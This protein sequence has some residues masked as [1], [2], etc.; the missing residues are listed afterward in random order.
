[1][2]IPKY[3]NRISTIT[4]IALP[5][6]DMSCRRNRS[7]KIVISNQNHS[8]KIN[9]EKTSA[10]KLGNVKPPG[11]NMSVLRLHDQVPGTQPGTQPAVS[12][13]T[14][15]TPASAACKASSLVSS[16]ELR[17]TMTPAPRNPAITLSVVILRISTKRAALPDRKVL[18]VCL[19]KSSSMPQA[20]SWPPNALDEVPVPGIMKKRQ[21]NEFHGIPGTPP[22][23]IGWRSWFNFTR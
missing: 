23:V 16:N 10:R 14:A 12:T 9:I 1:M 2:N 11:N 13:D 4:Q 22:R 17:S 5:Q 7:P 20:A 18:A 6:P 3:E 8:T 19:M 15:R 21:I